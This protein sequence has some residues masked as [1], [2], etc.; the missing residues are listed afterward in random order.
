M[1]LPNFHCFRMTN[2]QR[3]CRPCPNFT[4]D[5]W[6]S[7]LSFSEVGGVNAP[8][9]ESYLALSAQIGTANN[10][11]RR[12]TRRVFLV[13]IVNSNA[14]RNMHYS[15]LVTRLLANDLQL[16]IVYVTHF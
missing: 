15:H 16:C 7:L 14:S 11:L 5:R 13:A 9:P 8:W 6:A 4:R 10:S 2:A 12:F 1:L 3:F